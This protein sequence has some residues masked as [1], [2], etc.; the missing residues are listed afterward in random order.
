MILEKEERIRENTEKGYWRRKETF[1]DDF[2]RNV[3]WYPKRMALVD[4]PNKENLVG[5]KPER[6]TYKELDRAVDAVAT[7]FLEMGV[8]KDDVIIMQIPNTWE[9][10][11]LSP[12]PEQGRP[13]LLCPYSGEKK[14]WVIWGI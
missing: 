11:M 3:R 1:I 2:K 7:A 6:L 10:A 5:L 12:L 4:P 14:T 13:L 9:L 8:K